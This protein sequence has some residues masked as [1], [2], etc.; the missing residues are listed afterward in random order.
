MVL[1]EL[2][3]A[4]RVLDERDV[5]ADQLYAFLKVYEYSVAVL[6]TEGGLITYINERMSLAE[7]HEG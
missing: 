2:R 4:K 5:P 7:K 1:A 6:M 3:A